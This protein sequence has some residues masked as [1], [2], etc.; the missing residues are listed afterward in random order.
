MEVEVGTL[1]S[2]QDD[3]PHHTLHEEGDPL[4]SVPHKRPENPA[5][6]AD[7]QQDQEAGL[8]SPNKRQK[9][10]EGEKVTGTEPTKD[11]N[12]NKPPEREDQAVEEEEKKM[13]EEKP[14]NICD[15]DCGGCLEF[16]G[17]TRKRCL[18]CGCMLINHIPVSNEDFPCQDDDDDYLP[19]YGN[20]EDPWY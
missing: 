10:E 6:S 12:D 7:Q 20:E 16:L 14:W 1:P 5:T 13:I 8:A 3:A 4:C 15:G 11:A 2:M 18:N 19:E 17:E 9:L